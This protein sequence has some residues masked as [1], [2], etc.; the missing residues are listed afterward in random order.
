MPPAATTTL[1]I[2]RDQTTADPAA[3]EE[4]AWV[5][6]ARAGDAESTLRLLRR[7]RPPLVRL[8][9]GVTGDAA[10]AEDL[11][12]EAFLQA[13][14]RLHQLRDPAAFYPWVRRT[15]MRLTLKRL[16]T[17]PVVCLDE[18][19]EA[20]APDLIASAET[21]LAV[22]EVLRRLPG[23]LRVTLVLRELE[24]LDYQ[25]IA[26]ALE[27]PVGT[28]RSRLFAARERFRILWA[29]IDEE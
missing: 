15:A 18:S 26:E 27:I 14:R 25:E 9:T 2:Q 22:E 13:F 7:Y 19:R 12:Q 11:A 24:R 8:L 23:E 5:E 6:G 3:A 4:A 29:E 16:P 1:Q 17:Q 10:L 21:R 20:P 28:V